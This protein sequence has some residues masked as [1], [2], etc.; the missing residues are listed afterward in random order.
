[1]AADVDAA[2]VGNTTFGDGL[3]AG[4]ISRM[5]LDACVRFD[6]TIW[7][8]EISGARL[9]ALMTG[10]NQGPDTAFQRREGEFMFADGPAQIDPAKR[11]RI[12]TNDWGVTN[13]ARYFGAETIEFRERKGLRLKS[14]V[15]AALAEHPGQS[16]AGGR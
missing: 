10:S 5:A 13:Q 2:F 6:G 11:Y 7:V 12:A 1:L 3:S 14:V 8:G 16:A 15:T 9:L 4:S